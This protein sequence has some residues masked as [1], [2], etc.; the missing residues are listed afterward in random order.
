MIKFSK[1]LIA[2]GVVTL[3]SV[4]GCEEKTETVP[5]IDIQIS[6]IS[7]QQTIRDSIIYVNNTKVLKMIET[8]ICEP[9]PIDKNTKM[10][11]YDYRIL[12]RPI[13][14]PVPPTLVDTFICDVW[15]RIK[16]DLGFNIPHTDLH[17]RLIIDAI[18][19][20]NKNDWQ[21]I[22]GYRPWTHWNFVKS[23]S[24]GDKN[25]LANEILN[26]IIRFGIRDYEEE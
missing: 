12:D 2:L 14:D 24:H 6:F 1:V 18:D 3:L 10:E 16:M 20:Y 11:P 25:I 21:K 17:L 22:A 9:Y 13:T 5:S 7:E 4:I 19:I 15:Q 23:L 8:Y 26:Y